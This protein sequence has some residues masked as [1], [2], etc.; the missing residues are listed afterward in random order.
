MGTYEQSAKRKVMLLIPRLIAACEH[1]LYILETLNGDEGLMRALVGLPV[2]NKSAYV[3]R[4]FQ[5]SIQISFRHPK[6]S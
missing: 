1:S 3:K 2:P 4:I 5:Q 6:E